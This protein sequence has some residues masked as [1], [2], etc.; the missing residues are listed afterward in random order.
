MMDGPMG[1]QID[2]P[3]PDDAAA[4]GRVQLTAW[5]QTYLNERVGIDEAWIHEHR[6]SA[7]TAE[8]I[9]Q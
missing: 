7:V 3:E 6:G 8:G 4:I 5:L 2:V 1:H 9:T